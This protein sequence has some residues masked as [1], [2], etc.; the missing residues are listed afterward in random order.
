MSKDIR[1]PKPKAKQSPFAHDYPDAAGVTSG[2]AGAGATPHK[3]PYDAGVVGETR[4]PR[5]DAQGAAGKSPWPHDYPHTSQPGHPK[6][7]RG[8]ARV[9]LT[10]MLKR[11]SRGVAKSMGKRV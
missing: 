2:N 10:H 9:P 7:Q 6:N 5:S 11:R 1:L 8:S 4:H 3:H